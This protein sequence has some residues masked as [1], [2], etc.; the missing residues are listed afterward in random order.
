M[1]LDLIQTPVWIGIVFV[2][3]CVTLKIKGEGK[4][5]QIDISKFGKWKYH[6]TSH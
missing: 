5:V 1:N 2:E 4:V 6:G 3:K